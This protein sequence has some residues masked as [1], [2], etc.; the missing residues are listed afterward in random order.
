MKPEQLRKVKSLGAK[1]AITNAGHH[2]MI[3]HGLARIDY[4]P[5]SEKFQMTV[6]SEIRRGFDQMFE[7]LKHA[8]MRSR[9]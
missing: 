9:Q 8:P 7:M 4:W 2:W 1:V 6:K 5:S 3:E